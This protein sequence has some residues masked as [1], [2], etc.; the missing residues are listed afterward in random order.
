LVSSGGGS[1]E[2]Q[3]EDKAETGTQNMFIALYLIKNIYAEVVT[4]W[5]SSLEAV[6][7]HS[8]SQ[9]K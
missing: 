9:L 2:A 8:L 7:L 1:L 4:H 5:A 6:G 3:K